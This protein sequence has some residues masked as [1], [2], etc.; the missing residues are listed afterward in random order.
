MG[1]NFGSGGLFSA[2]AM[3]ATVMPW[4]V[5][6]WVNWWAASVPAGGV[7]FAL[8]SA[9]TLDEWFVN[10]NSTAFVQ[11]T[12]V[13]DGTLVGTNTITYTPVA[14]KWYYVV[15]R[16]ISATNRWLSILP[17]GDG[18]AALHSQNTTSA[19]P[20]LSPV[21]CTIGADNNAGSG[22]A[23]TMAEFFFAKA[24]IQSDGLQL[25]DT[26]LRK[27]AY[28]GPLS[29]IRQDQ[30]IEYLQFRVWHDPAASFI[31]QLRTGNEPDYF[32]ARVPIIK[33]TQ[34]SGRPALLGIHPQLYTS[35]RNQRLILPRWRSSYPD[36]VSGATRARGFIIG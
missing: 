14:G 29:V 7:F 18:L 33:W 36:G 22:C 8:G 30:I 1:M 6:F 5:G 10:F 19:N 15:A 20:T 32:S 25:S 26:T 31:Q 35:Y 34:A 23:A 16:Y 9:D 13:S 2:S 28:E 17:H 21:V 27:L 24:D 12:A 4:T 11:S 3:P